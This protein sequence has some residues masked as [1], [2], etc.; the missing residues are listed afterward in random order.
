[1]QID[2]RRANETSCSGHDGSGRRTARF[3]E[4]E[5]RVI[6]QKV[7]LD[8]RVEQVESRQRQK[9]RPAESSRE[10]P[11]VRIARSGA[12]AWAAGRPTWRE[13][14][15]V[16]KR[17]VDR[18]ASNKTEPARS[19]HTHMPRTFIEE[20]FRPKPRSEPI[21]CQWSSRQRRSQGRKS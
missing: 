17:A 10:M 21:L 15:D 12:A 2:V 4:F 5:D 20:L 14:P 8:E 6:G 18:V 1:M 13:Q 16:R 11:R 19:S 9:A 7:G 3:F